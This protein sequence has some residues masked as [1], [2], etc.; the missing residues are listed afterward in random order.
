[1]SIRA[2]EILRPR[3]IASRRGRSVTAASGSSSPS[4]LRLDDHH[5][6]SPPPEPRL[7]TTSVDGIFVN[8][9][10]GGEAPTTRPESPS[11]YCV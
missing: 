1:V 11:P 7:Q 9:K 5:P 8:K 10:L 6:T 3:G 4:A 2:C